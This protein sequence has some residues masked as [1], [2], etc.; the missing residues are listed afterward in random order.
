MKPSHGGLKDKTH[1]MNR[2]PV[3]EVIKKYWNVSAPVVSP[4]APKQPAVTAPKKQE[5]KT[6]ELIYGIARKS[7][8]EEKA[9]EK[10]MWNAVG[11][12][13]GWRQPK[14]KAGEWTTALRAYLYGGYPVDTIRDF[15]HHKRGVTISATVRWEAKKK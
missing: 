6:V 15:L 13:F 12:S 9:A 2:K 5:Q 14:V 7:P 3:M 11:K 4:S 8:A 10:R 1:D